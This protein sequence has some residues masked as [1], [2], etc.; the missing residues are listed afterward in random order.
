MNKNRRFWRGLRE[1]FNH[2][3]KS[4]LT[5]RSS[6][7]F[8]RFY[9]AVI[10]DNHLFEKW[11]QCEKGEIWEDY[12][13]W[14]ASH[15]LLT[16]KEWFSLHRESL[17]WPTPPKISIVT[18]VY[19]TEIEVLY[20]CVLS[21]RTQAY[22]YW[23]L[24]LVDDASS[25]TK[26]HELL[27][28]SVFKDP[29]IQ[30]H[31]CEESQG[32]SQATNLAIEKSTGDFIVF[33][34]HDD[35]LSLDA[36]FYIAKEIIDHPNVDIIYSDRDMLTPKDKR[37][38]HLFKPDWSPESLLSGNYVFHLMCYRK[39]LLSQL[40]GLRS[41]FDGSQD[42]DLVLR[43]A[44]TTSNV[45]HIKR[46]LYHWRQYAGSVSL[47][48]SAKDYAFKAGVAA[49]N[50][51]LKRRKIEGEAKEIDDMWRG[52]Y[53]LDLVCPT[54]ENIQIINID[55]AS[56]TKSYAS[57]I[58]QTLKSD[59]N[60]SPFI[61]IVSNAITPINNNSI[62]HLAAWLQMKNI[63][64][65]SGSM[66]TKDQTIEYAGATLS[67]D[68]SIL[69]PYQGHPISQAGYMAVTRLV[70]NISAP[71]PHCIVLRRELWEQLS[72]FNTQYQGFYALFDFTLRALENNWRCLSI[73]QAKF[74][75]QQP[76]LLDT[77]IEK[78]KQLFKHAWHEWLEK[79][80]PY[81]NKNLDSNTQD[82]LFHLL[83]ND[84]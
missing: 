30:V 5:T 25:S 62:T 84:I 49:L 40:G 41:E 16:Q 71:H 18:P 19:N 36:F 50:D 51:A 59:K 9:P 47:D 29:R 52:N 54:P 53:Y 42:Y 60:N 76:N 27:N 74:T 75:T 32:I 8:L 72:G 82:K 34:D 78:D 67:K 14:I 63:G 77:Y 22:P 44:E 35:R 4:Y 56:I 48:S 58:N 46:I 38:M 10:P 6:W 69:I 73:P 66:M 81:Y 26:T 65:V 45:R 80:D 3:P 83:M 24:I 31:F 28:S 61:A 64:I 23:Q 68:A 15:T 43:A 17:S 2:L 11:N 1:I 37:F 57:F 12:Q 21:V 39:T 7:R 20:E 70:R 13:S 33:L 55:A 79:G